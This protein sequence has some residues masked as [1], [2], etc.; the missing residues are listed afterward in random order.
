MTLGPVVTGTRLSEDEVVGSEELT[1]WSG[2]DGV[3]GSWFE[4]HEDGSWDVSSSGGFVEVDV[5]SLELEIG[6]SVVCT[7]WVNTVLISDDL[8][9]LGTDLVTTLTGLDMND[10]SHLNLI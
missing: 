7:G 10:F 3:H 4:I 1:E 5:D 9:E 8:P 2:S 6:V